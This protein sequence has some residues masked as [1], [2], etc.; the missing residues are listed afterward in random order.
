MRF[1]ISLGMLLGMSHGWL[2]SEGR[3]STSSDPLK[4]VQ[5]VKSATEFSPFST[6]P[7]PTF[8]Y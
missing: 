2:V 1:A 4:I 3:A 7:F 8:P 6:D 5:T